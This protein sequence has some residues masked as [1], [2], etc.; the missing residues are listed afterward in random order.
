MQT[1]ANPSQYSKLKPVSMQNSTQ[2]C[3]AL[4]FDSPMYA[5]QRARP[6]EDREAY[7]QI[8]SDEAPAADS[9]LD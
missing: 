5:R 9:K 4:F 6:W 2:H 1:F 7:A 8:V 3:H